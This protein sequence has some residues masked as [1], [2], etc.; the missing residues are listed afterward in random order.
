MINISKKIW[1]TERLD[2]CDIAKYLYDRYELEFVCANI[3]N[4]LWYYYKNNKWDF[5]C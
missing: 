5:N 3:K 1:F 2:P 4:N